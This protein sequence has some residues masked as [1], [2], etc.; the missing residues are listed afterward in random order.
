M[1]LFYLMTGQE[2]QAE[3]QEKVQRWL[4]TFSPELPVVAIPVFNAY[5]ALAACLD[6]LLATM[7]AGTPLLLLDD[8][9]PD[10]RIPALVERLD[11]PNLAYVR[12]AINGGF[13]ETVNLA[14]AWSAPR[15]VVVANSDTLFP[16]GWLERLRAAATARPEIATVTPLTNHGS[17]LSVPH[18][19]VEVPE[20]APGMAV[21]EADARIQ[22]ASLRLW[23]VIP[24]AVGHCVYFRRAA[25]EAVG[26][27]D[28][29]FSPGYGEEVDFSQRAVLA[30]FAHVAADDLFIFHQGSGSFGAGGRR[31]QRLKQ[32][33]EQIVRRRYPWYQPW[34]T[35]VARDPAGPLALAL[36]RARTAL[37][38]YRLAVDATWLGDDPTPLGFLHALAASPTRN[39][40]LTLLVNEKSN[41]CSHPGLAADEIIPVSRLG[42]FEAPPFD[43]V[44]RPAPVTSAGELARLAW[45]G[46]RFVVAQFDPAAFSRPGPDTRFSAWAAYRDLTRLIF[47]AADGLVFAGPEA[48]Q[49][50]G[51]VGLL[52]P[53]ERSWT[54]PAP[55]G[56]AEAGAAMA[57]GLEEFCNAILSLPPCFGN[58]TRLPALPLV[59]R[60]RQKPVLLWRRWGRPALELLRTH[61]LRALLAEV[62]D[63]VRWRW[64]G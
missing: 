45:L 49:A 55:T 1:S 20:P 31:K 58:F 13:V 12:K 19:N 46:R 36:D 56:Q 32:A 5:A 27:F 52:L 61:G 8:A 43:L 33:H 10:E 57:A 30:G 6:S 14:F 47:A 35:D 25:L 21:A 7:P 17:I 16:P 9:S 38:G 42:A 62:W 28:P 60:W 24:A 26:G 64:L 18:R 3:A 44:Y 2:T 50:A 40:H 53:A 29:V 63:Q 48:V 23:P 15:D 4:V 37:L 34:V 11:R 59:V 54:L 41:L 51:Q 39:F 22:A